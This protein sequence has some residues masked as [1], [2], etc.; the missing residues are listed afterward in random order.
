MFPQTPNSVKELIFMPTILI[1]CSGNYCRSP[2]AEALV[3]LHLQQANV[4]RSISVGSAGITENYGG[5][6]PAPKVIEVLREL[7]ADG[8]NQQPHFV[9]PAEIISARLIFGIAQ[10]HVDWIKSNYPEATDR[11]YLLTDLIGEA[12]DIFDPGPYKLEA[13]RVCRDT[14][15]RIIVQGLPE[16][17]RRLKPPAGFSESS[18]FLHKPAGG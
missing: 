18:S 6:P 17:M 5:Q 16:L 9:Q 2:L 14:I 3:R 11:T 8:S 4:D 15:D 1:L 10:E 7:G 12:W 13:I